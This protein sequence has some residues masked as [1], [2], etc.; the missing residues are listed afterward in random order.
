MKSFLFG[1]LLLGICGG[2]FAKEA[3]STPRE[4]VTATST[5]LLQILN[6]ESEKLKD[7]PVKLNNLVYEVILPVIDF[8]TFAK[9]TLGHHWRTATP[10]QRKRF[11]NEFRGMLIRTYT[12]YLVDYAGT[13]VTVLPP[14]GR[15]TNR[16]QVVFT[17]VNQPGKPPLPVD[18]SFR[19]RKG[20]WKAYNVTV[21]GI[22]LVQLFR[23]N[24]GQE[25]AQTSLNALIE[26]L[27]NTKESQL[28]LDKTA[29]N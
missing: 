5:Q 28:N 29:E 24:F 17:E 9:L 14:R 23:T 6:A 4:L 20:E 25:I 11:A 15:Q 12:K 10:E 2:T 27:S 3:V 1:V 13:E 16:R 7:D 21:D 8:S 19:F 22:S 26:R 18:Y